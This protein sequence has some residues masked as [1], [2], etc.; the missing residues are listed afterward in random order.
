ML[1]HVH[2]HG[3]IVDQIKT[4]NGKEMILETLIILKAGQPEKYTC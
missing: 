2:S 4:V 3:I 1:R